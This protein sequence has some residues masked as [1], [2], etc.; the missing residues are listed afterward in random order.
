MKIQQ[1]KVSELK[2]FSNNNK[3]HPVKQVEMIANSIVQFGFQNPVIVDKEMNVIA[4]H[5]RLLAAQQLGMELVPCIVAENLT[6]EQVRAYR[7]LDNKIGDFGEYNTEN[8]L[9][10]L[11]AIGN[12]QLGLDSLNDIFGVGDEAKKEKEDDV[13]VANANSIVQEGDIFELWSHRLMCWDSTKKEAVD[14]LMN[15]AKADMVRTD[16]PYNVAYHGQSENT[17]QGIMNDKMDKNNFQLFLND[18]FKELAE[19][20]KKWGGIYIRHNHKEQIAF[21][22]AIEANGMEIKHQII[23]NKPSLG[24]GWGDYRPKHEVCFYCATKGAQNKFYGDRTHSTV[25]DLWKEK[26]DQQILNM[27]K[28]GRKAEAEG[29][30]TIFSIKRDNVNEYVH[31]TQKPVEL[32]DLSIL[33]NSKEEDIVLDLFAGS[34]VCLISCEKNKRIFYW[35]E[36]DPRYVETILLRYLLYTDD[37]DSIKCLNRDIDLDLILRT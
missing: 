14:K 12:F 3:D 26:T 2:P 33:N 27:I 28:L 23:W 5:G 29:K 35:M 16:P 4:W 13:P 32:C 17:R 22:K 19:H 34:G 21:Q 20:V 30:T 37:R 25:V 8:I 10:E 15:W 9:K 31:P 36:L 11:E 1:I 18:S 6:E 24:L 7:L